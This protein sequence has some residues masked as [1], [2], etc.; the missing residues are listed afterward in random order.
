MF[1]F[2]L[3]FLFIQRVIIHRLRARRFDKVI[4]I[5]RGFALQRS[6]VLCR[7]LGPLGWSP[8]FWGTSL[9]K[10]MRLDFFPG[11]QQRRE[12]PRDGQL[13]PT[14]M[15][16]SV[17]DKKKILCCR[18]SRCGCCWFPLPASPLFRISDI[19]SR[20]IVPGVS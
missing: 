11:S 8:L 7:S 16:C 12:H 9:R 2:L 19:P 14:S 17:R 13:Y 10:A 15:K 5:A 18:T 3:F 1:F 20:G 4:V 6:V